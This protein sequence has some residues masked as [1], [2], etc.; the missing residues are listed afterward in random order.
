M[1]INTIRSGANNKYV[2]RLL[3]ESFREGAKVR[4][5]TLANLSQWSEERLSELRSA[6]ALKRR[7]RGEPAEVEADELILSLF[8][9][10]RWAYPWQAFQ[11]MT[12]FR[13]ARTNEPKRANLMEEK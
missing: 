11:L 4:K 6:L 12:R 10:H 3:R 2:K 9:G 8:A 7:T 13:N 1:H 5:R